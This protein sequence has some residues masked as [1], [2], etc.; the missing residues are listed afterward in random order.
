MSG[1]STGRISAIEKKRGLARV[2]IWGHFVDA[3]VSTIQP[4]TEAGVGGLGFEFRGRRVVRS[5][6][7]EVR[8]ARAVPS[9]CSRCGPAHVWP[10]GCLAS[11]SRSA[12]RYAL[13]I[14]HRPPATAHCPAHN[15]QP[16]EHKAPLSRKTEC[17]RSE[18]RSEILL[19]HSPTP[20]PA[21]YSYPSHPPAPS[22]P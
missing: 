20:C 8:R 14:D 16:T 22:P 12:S 3:S 5:A 1:S 6:K 18:S 17:E 11:H 10:G 4:S 7:C 21:L 9:M 2:R 19:A 13:S 15:P